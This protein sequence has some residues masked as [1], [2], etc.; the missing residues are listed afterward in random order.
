MTNFSKITRS[1]LLGSI[2]STAMLASSVAASA[3]AVG[4]RLSLDSLHA[5][6]LTNE[7][8]LWGETRDEVY[9]RVIGRT[10][11]GQPIDMRLPST[12]ISDDYIPFKQ[13]DVRSARIPGTFMNQDYYPVQAPQIWSGILP[14]DG[15]RAEFL[16]II[17][18]QDNATLGKAKEISK[19][20]FEACEVIAKGVAEATKD[21]TAKQ[22]S[23]ACKVAKEASKL[24]PDNDPHEYIGA[25]LVQAA[26]VG[27]VPQVTFMP[28]NGEA[29][30]GSDAVTKLLNGPPG[31][32]GV[33]ALSGGLSGNRAVFDMRDNEGVGHY[34]TTVRAEFL[35][36]YRVKQ[37]YYRLNTRDVERGTCRGVIRPSRLAQTVTAIL[38]TPVAVRMSVKSVFSIGCTT[39][40][41]CSGH[42]TS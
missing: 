25:F 16:V 8:T 41:S 13:G 3:E 28:A 30:G 24:L 23:A 31:S 19:V 6:K 10:P 38:S 34:Q 39:A 5:L 22:I 33:V 9:I 26:N 40:T 36:P 14:N 4:V 29:V 12:S 21:E 32:L 37:G 20:T 27:G 17:Q 15:D 11:D 2:T 1:M 35:E 42:A 7:R 18:E